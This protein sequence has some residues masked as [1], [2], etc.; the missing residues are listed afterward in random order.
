M[1]HAWWGGGGEG[2]RRGGLDRVGKGQKR[3]EDDIIWLV[4]GGIHTGYST[5]KP[6]QR[7]HLLH[8]GSDCFGQ[9][10]TVPVSTVEY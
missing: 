1:G 9:I 6:S 3:R 2:R 7:A 8:Y 5:L 10:L 4:G